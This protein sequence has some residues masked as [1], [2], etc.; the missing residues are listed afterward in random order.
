M[1]IRSPFLYLI[2]EYIAKKFNK[3]PGMIENEFFDFK[4][5]F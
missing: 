5:D 2:T 4:T 1:L 3:N